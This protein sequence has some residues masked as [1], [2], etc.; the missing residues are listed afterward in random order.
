MVL[1]VILVLED[2]AVFILEASNTLK[3]LLDYSYSILIYYDQL[4]LSH[5]AD[6]L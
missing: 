5:L 6:S 3:T 4:K 1:L 2:M